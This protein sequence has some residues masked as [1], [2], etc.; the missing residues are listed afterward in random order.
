MSDEAAARR[1]IDDV[2][3]GWLEDP[4]SDVVWIGDY[5]GRRAVRM[6]QTVRETTT[7]W[8]SAGQ[9]TLMI[10]AFVLSVPDGSPAEVYRQAL[11]RSFGTRRIHFALDPRRDLVLVGRM[12]L[13]EISEPELELAL[14]EIY[15]LVEVSFLPL[16]RAA[17]SP[18][19]GREKSP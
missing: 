17:G 16:L 8:F 15:D 12:P 6:R 2:T 7:V 19:T 3:V 4:H 11:S 10:E 14:G 18:P 5:E 1:L 13:G 9:R